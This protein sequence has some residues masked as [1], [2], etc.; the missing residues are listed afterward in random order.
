MKV[1]YLSLKEDTPKRGFWDY[2][3]ISDLLRDFDFEEVDT[4]PKVDSAVVVIP[5]RSHSKLIKEINKELSNIGGVVLML[6]GDEEGDFP[7]EEIKHKSIKIWVQNPQLGRHDEY[8]K[9]GTGYTTQLRDFK[10]K[11][12]DKTLQWMFAGQ[13]THSRREECAE[14]LRNIDI[15]GYLLESKGF[16][17]GIEPIEYIKKMSQSKVCPCPSGPQTPDSFRLFEALELGCVP[18]A[19]TQTSTEDWAG[20]WEWL[21]EEPVPF[22]TVSNWE[23]LPGYIKDCLEKYPKINNTIQS[24]W[25]RYKNKMWRT[26]V[27]DSNE[28]GGNLST[29]DIT[30]IIPVSPI[31]SNPDTFIVDEAI[32]N[33]RHH[34]P[35]AE[36]IVTFDGVRTEQEDR[37]DAYHEHIRRFLWK[38]SGDLNIVPYIYE[39]HMH[40]IGM[41]RD[42]IDKINTPLVMY[43]EQDTPIVIDETIDWGEVCGLI[44]SGK[45]NLVRFHF[46]AI[47]PKEHKHLMI[48]K[49]EGGFLKTVQWS[50]RPH[51]ASTAFYKRILSENF[52]GKSRCFIEDLM[53]GRVM[54]DWNRYGVQG[55]NQWKLHI[56]HPEGG[57]IKRS[58]HTDGRAGANKF[59]EKQIW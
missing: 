47:I 42:I 27:S 34:L 18:I 52:S 35:K 12:V 16:T 46:E 49:P 14:Q 51:V 36:I 4:L 30:V 32:A 3:F 41:A 50:Q 13:V 59:D 1:Y 6:M 33:V 31:P 17:E 24:W 58:Y 19:D 57:N 11:G 9:L 39:K 25:M 23:S 10:P 43:V 28:V 37:T 55:W 40:Q 20:F 21:F 5:A 44:L 8:R 56:Y 54:N 22:P 26:L 29:Q 7:V 45:S 38:H 2:G 53:H 15:P 48:G